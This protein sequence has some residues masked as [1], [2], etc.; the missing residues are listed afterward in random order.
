VQLLAH[1]FLCLR[2]QDPGERRHLPF[3]LAGVEDQPVEGNERRQTREQRQQN[4]VGD[5][6]RDEE[7]FC[8]DTSPQERQRMSFQPRGGIS[9]G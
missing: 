5:A 1:E 3:D 8:S 4:G 2:R 9:P 6:A 7:R